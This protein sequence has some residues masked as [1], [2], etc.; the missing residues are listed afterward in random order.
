MQLHTADIKQRSYTDKGVLRLS[1][2]S[3]LVMAALGGMMSPALAQPA[4]PETDTSGLG[5]IIVTAQRRAENLQ[6]VPIAVSAVGEQQLKAVGAVDTTSLSTVVSGLNI[7]VQAASFQPRI[8]GIGTGAIGP[9]IENPV[10]LYVDNVYIGPQVTGLANLADVAQVTVLKGPQGTLFGRNSTGGVIQM[11][12]RDP[13]AEPGG[14]IR[15]EIDNYATTRNNIYLTGGLSDALKANLSVSYTHQGEGW[16]K[17]IKTGNDNHKIDHDFSVRN[18]WLFTPSD[19]T[20]LKL[21]LDYSDNKN[22]MGPNLVPI[23]GATTLVPGW[24]ATGPYDTDLTTDNTIHLKSGGVGLEASQDL[25][26]ARLVSIS[27]Y[28]KYKFTELFD[29]SLSPTQTILQFLG[30]KGHQFSQELQLLSPEG[31]DKLKW[32]LGLYY[33]NAKDSLDPPFDQHNHGLTI[34][35]F[36]AGADDFEILGS[37]DMKTISKSAFGQATYE[38][39]P[40]TRLTLGLR[41]TSEIRKIDAAINFIG[42]FPFFS[43]GVQPFGAQVGRNKFNKLTWRIALDHN[44]TDDIL[45]YVSYNRGFKSGGFNGLST[46][47]PAYKPEIVDAYEAGLKTELFD[48]HVRLNAA[49]FY[50]TYKDIQIIE[51]INL[52]SIRNAAKA[53]TYGADFDLEAKLTDEL[54]LNSGVSL[55]HT[56]FGAGSIGTLAGAGASGSLPGGSSARGPINGNP[57]AF[58]PKFTAN[59]SATYTKKLDWGTVDF[60]VTNAYNSGFYGAED[61]NPLLHQKAFDYLNTALTWTSTN[62]G[63]SLGIW[64]RNLLNKVVATQLA[65][66]T[67]GLTSDYGNP[68]RTYGA[69][70]TVRFGSRR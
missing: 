29:P 46:L 67:L 18:K 25:G 9:G 70:A 11:T 56:K 19:A 15:S 33:F 51:F 58:A 68:P 61:K 1:G 16:G 13:V 28:R 59:V 23:P 24:A 5:E 57:L 69:T 35:P 64:G 31:N 36:L 32:V 37:A 44:F 12:T 26:F 20:T 47:D 45:G 4:A 14:E 34:P 6:S 8:R 30:Q 3:V 39:L 48:R 27:A 66:G 38:F 21:S 43:T 42:H 65:N 54:R 60:N 41:Y 63:I 2:A 55:L 62:G 10:A 17:N 52:P 49:F 7:Q 22:S 50:N 40:D 53:K